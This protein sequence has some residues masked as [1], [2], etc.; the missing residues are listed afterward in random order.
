MIE[1]LYDWSIKGYDVILWIF[2]EVDIIFDVV[3][4]IIFQMPRPKS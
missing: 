3:Q 1:I 2:F 4:K